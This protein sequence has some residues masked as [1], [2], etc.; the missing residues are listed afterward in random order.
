MA[1]GAS[2]TYTASSAWTN[3]HLWF[4]QDP[5]L[6]TI[7][8]VLYDGTTSNVVDWKKTRFGFKEEYIVNGTQF[9]LNGKRAFMRGDGHHYQGEY[10][11]TREY[12]VAMFT[13]MKQW[14]VNYFRPHSMPYD[15][16][17][18]DVADSMGMMILDESAIYGSD[19]DSDCIHDDRSHLQRFIERDRNHPSVWAWSVSNELGWK[20]SEAGTGWTGLPTYLV[21][22]DSL[23]RAVD[24]T[25]I[26]YNE[27]DNPAGNVVHSQHYWDFT[28]CGPDANLPPL[29]NNTQVHVMGEYCNYQIYCFTQ[30]GNTGTCGYE[31]TSQDYGTGY[32]T[33]GETAR[34]QTKSLQAQKL[35]RVFK[36]VHALVFASLPAV[37]QQ[38]SS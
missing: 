4:P 15:P 35:R 12:F 26:A 36:L 27:G 28:T 30:P 23:A 8:T 25:R 6:Y 17:M 7:H 33:H 31:A 9:W 24:P 11:Q 38:H 1:A 22:Y 32:W 21:A 34:D 20:E 16:V 2:A 14:G 18:L 5:Y 10:Q 3:P 29:A 37:F 19:G 13:A